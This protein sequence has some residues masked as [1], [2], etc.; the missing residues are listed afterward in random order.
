[1]KVRQRGRGAEGKRGRRG[2]AGLT[3]LMALLALTV[4]LGAQDTVQRIRPEAI[5][6]DSAAILPD[7]VVQ[8]VIAAYNDSLTTRVIGPF[9]LPPGARLEG[10]VAVFGGSIR[11][12]G[13][14]TGRLIVINGY[15]ILDSGGVVRGDV[16]V[17]GG[18]VL[19][20][21]G[22]RLE[23]Q[24]REYR[25]RAQLVRTGAGLLAPRPPPRSLTDLASARR[26]FTTG[27]FRT[28]LSIESGQTYNRVVGLPIVLGPTI[29][30]EGLPNVEGR[31]D[32]RA[33]IWTAPD[34]TDRRADFGYAARLEFK[35]GEAR[36]LTVGAAGSRQI[37]PIEPEPLS[38]GEAGWAAFLLQRDYRDY[39]QAEGVEGYASYR[40]GPG[41]ALHGSLRRDYER[42]VP[43]ADPLSVFR[44][45]SWRPNP[46]VDDG[47]YISLR[48]GFQVDTRND[49][50][51]PAAGWLVHG[52]WERSRSTDALPISLPPEVREPIGTGPYASTRVRLDARRYDRLN[53]SV[54]IA[55]RVVAAGWIGGDPL[56]LQRRVSLGGPDQLPGYEFRSQNCAPPSFA[57]PGNPA[58]CDRMLAAQLEIRTRTRI[59]L[60]IA[61]TN[62]YLS[63]AQRVL[64]IRD[65]DVVV[66]GGVGK[67][68]VT[69]DG[70]G[71][72][73][74]N[75]IPVF[76]EWEK[77][78][79]LGLD[80][81]RLAFYIAQ[82]VARGRPLTFTA[83]LQQRF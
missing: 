40:F 65:P 39:Y 5:R 49:P 16:L 31:M 57:E 2:A 15:L 30:R 36:K 50:E 82:P 52:I 17:V 41:L 67:A 25:A 59:G 32:L 75:R 73:P 34:R 56:P 48:F 9:H 78:F 19:R 46:L 35:F 44:N 11:V 71:R 37:L 69:G 70:P 18:Q 76:S 20:R 64:G 54:R 53:P 33:T 8:E 58:L 79:G 45:Q 1:M 23:G 12:G 26:S 3:A 22:A 61:F 10:P 60:P 72:V 51:N 68:W 42:S 77:D 6:A 28:T 55:L 81:G 27:R 43:A 14:L 62:P 38:A 24:L 47:H 63:G 74:N 7:A 66:F 83:R 80:F 21:P 29:T 4:P 13:E